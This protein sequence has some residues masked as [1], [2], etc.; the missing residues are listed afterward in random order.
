MTKL[1]NPKSIGRAGHGAS[2]VDHVSQGPSRKREPFCTW[3]SSTDKA[4][5]SA[6]LLLLLNTFL[7]TARKP[8]QAL[9]GNTNILESLAF[10]LTFRDG[11]EKIGEGP[12]TG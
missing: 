2:D 9:S 1:T 3:I 10:V 6:T 4:R 5:S 11:W 7:E 12:P 8:F